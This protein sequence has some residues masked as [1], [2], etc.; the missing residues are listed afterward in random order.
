MKQ[1]YCKKYQ[2]DDYMELQDGNYSSIKDKVDI[3]GKN[4]RSNQDDKN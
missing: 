2:T 3:S 4:P 1:Y